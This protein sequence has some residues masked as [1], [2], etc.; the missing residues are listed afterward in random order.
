MT[1]KS[2][3]RFQLD[4]AQEKASYTTGRI[5]CPFCQREELTGIID[6]AGPMLLV[7]NKFQMLGDAYQTVLIETDVCT[8]DITTYAPEYM[9]RLLTFGIGV[10][11]EGV[12]QLRG[13]RPL[14]FRGVLQEPRAPVRG[15]HSPCPFSDRGPGAHR[16]SQRHLRCHF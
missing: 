10:D 12:F 3:L 4:I 1:H 2:H 13:H 9:Q 16:L 11:T 14:C 6:A 7:E 15:H 8:E 5:Q